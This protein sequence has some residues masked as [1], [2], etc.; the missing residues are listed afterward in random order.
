MTLHDAKS[1]LG[2]L[3]AEEELN[4]IKYRDSANIKS[5]F[6]ALCT[7]WARANNQG[8]DIDDKHFRAYVIKSMP[9]AWAP[10]TGALFDMKTSAE[11]IVR[12]TTHALLL[13]GPAVIAPVNSIHVLATQTNVTQNDKTSKCNNCGRTGHTK[14]KCFRKGNG[15]EGQYPEW[16]HR[17]KDTTSMTSGTTQAPAP[18]PQA[19]TTQMSSRLTTR[20]ICVVSLLQ[21]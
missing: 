2:L 21:L 17:N 6:R 16:W 7:A 12:L 1:D 18:T 3:Q 13:H 11:V 14:E 8:A 15:M 10:V 20:Q 9:S 19:N 5:H 4:S